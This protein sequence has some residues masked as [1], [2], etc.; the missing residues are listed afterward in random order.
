[1]KTYHE[2][3]KMGYNF[4]RLPKGKIHCEHELTGQ[5][6]IA[7]MLTIRKKIIL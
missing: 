4:T 5:T 1:M 6:I 2:P 3:I 7:S